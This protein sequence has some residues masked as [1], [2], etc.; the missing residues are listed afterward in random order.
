MIQKNDDLIVTIEDYSAEGQGVAKHEGYVLFVAG[1]VVGDKVRVH[2]LK[3]GKNFG[4]A[5]VSEIITP[6]PY[7][8]ASDCDESIRCGG[9][10]FRELDYAEELRRK[11]AKVR[12][13][14]IR[15]GGI[16]NPPMRPIIAAPEQLGYR[17]KAQYPIRRQNGQTVAGFY[18]AGSH[19]VISCQC[20]IQ[21]TV[22]DEILQAVLALC[23]QYHISAYDE[24]QNSGMLR[25]LYLREGRT[26]GEIMVCFVITGGSLPKQ[27]MTDLLARFPAIKCLCQ[28][29]NSKRTNVIMGDKTVFFTPDKFITDT[30]CGME[31]AI[32]PASFFQVN[33]AQ[34][35]RLYA[36]AAALADVTEKQTV[37]DLYCGIGTVG[38]CAAR[39]AK[40]LVGIEIVPEA[41]ENAKQNAARNQLTNT[42][43]LCADAKCGTARL[44]DEGYHFDTVFVDPPRKG[45]DSQTLEALLSLA[46]QKIVYIS[47]DPATLARDVKVLTAGGYTLHSATPVDMFPR[48]THVETVVLLSRA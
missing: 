44:L 15:I 7:R 27:M 5:K 18:A 25:H 43:Y 14:L 6:S 33:P 19:R 24:Q 46:P 10:V 23:E 31:F 35:E 9:C 16:E 20:R 4:Y 3:C 47:C 34:T 2:V 26:S 17:N 45:C 48:T 37:L 36:T 42:R 39:N 1:G 30:L 29:I 28:N 12:E 11:A 40:H 22:F 41:I 13:N 8:I 21:P 32:A 38:M